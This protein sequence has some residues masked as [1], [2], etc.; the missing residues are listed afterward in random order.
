MDSTYLLRG[1]KSTLLS[2]SEFQAHPPS[3]PRHPNMSYVAYGHSRRRLTGNAIIESAGKQLKLDDLVKQGSIYRLY[4]LNRL[5]RGPATRNLNAR[6]LSRRPARRSSR[7]QS[8][9]NC[10]RKTVAC[11]G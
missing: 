11:S 9:I 2:K 7:P 10:L 5:P 4:S 1:G 3:H 8:S 6:T